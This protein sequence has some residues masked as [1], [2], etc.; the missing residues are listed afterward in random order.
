MK[1]FQKGFTLIELM[2]VVAIIGILAAIAIPAYQDYTIRAQV[3]EGLTLASDIKAGVAEYMAQT[4]SW[5]GQTCG[6][7]AWHQLA[8]TSRGRSG[9]A[10]SSRSM[11]ATGTIHDRVRQRTQTR[12]STDQELD[13]PALASTP[14]A[15]SPGSA[16]MRTDR[17]RTQT[18]IPGSGATAFA[19]RRH[20]AGRQ[21]R[22]GFIAAL[23][24]RRQLIGNV[25]GTRC[26]ARTRQ[27]PLF[28]GALLLLSA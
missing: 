15:T 2:I 28:A 14:I 16:A 1:T 13:S 27:G 4:G 7:R 17:E 21:A 24:F 25:T 26:R 12:R 6:K 8:G 11:S 20:D 22:A 23:G 18:P 3:T 5:P 9:P 10:M 19:G